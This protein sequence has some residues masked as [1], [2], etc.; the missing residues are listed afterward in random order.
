M[1]TLTVT[2]SHVLDQVFN[3]FCI[4]FP[5]YKGLVVLAEQ[6]YVILVGHLNN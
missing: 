2:V 1:L 4:I 6:K 5:F 3:L